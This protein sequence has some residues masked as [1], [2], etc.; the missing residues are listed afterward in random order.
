MGGYIERAKRALGKGIRYKLGTGGFY[1]FAPLPCNLLLQCD[2]S[3]FV[4][5]VIGLSR[6]PKKSRDWW[7]ETSAIWNDAKYHQEVFVETAPAPNTVCVFP[8]RGKRQGHCG[9]VVSV[10]PNGQIATVIDCTP[11][12]G[13]A[14]H[15][16]KYFNDHPETIC[17]RL[18]QDG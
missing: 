13:V 2:C 17:V 8:D 10:T 6:K 1:P 11:S 12:R 18:K 9:I 7:I 4:S 14:V 3:G 16:G 15:S 5:W